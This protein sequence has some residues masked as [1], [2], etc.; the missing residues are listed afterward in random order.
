MDREPCPSPID[1]QQ[2]WNPGALHLPQSPEGGYHF[3][4]HHLQ[5]EINSTPGPRDDAISPGAT[6]PFFQRTESRELGIL[7]WPQGNPPACFA[8]ASPGGRIASPSPFLASQLQTGGSETLPSLAEA[9][10]RQSP[11]PD[12]SLAKAGGCPVGPI[13]HGLWLRPPCP[14]QGVPLPWILILPWFYPWVG[15]KMRLLSA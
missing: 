11:S 14:G 10:E 3:L 8:E 1:T 6:L 4:W 7:T 12:Q 2:E 9:Q 15:G 13:R 5:P